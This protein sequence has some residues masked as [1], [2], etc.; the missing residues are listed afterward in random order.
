MD[1]NNMYSP[2]NDQNQNDQDR[3][4]QDYASSYQPPQYQPPQYSSDSQQNP[5]GANDPY[6][7]QTSYQSGQQGEYDSNSAYQAPQYQSSPYQS[8]PYSYQAEPLQTQGGSGLAIG[9]MVCGILS[10]VFCCG[11]WISWILSVVAIVLGAVSISK[12]RRGKGMAMAG[13]ITGAVGIVLSI[14]ILIVA[15]IMGATGDLAEYS[16]YFDYYY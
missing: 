5:Y 16:H 14:L 8:S 1:P 13:I 2:N 6:A 7:S 15:G 11:S 12:G 9:S 3:Q 4:A 10:I